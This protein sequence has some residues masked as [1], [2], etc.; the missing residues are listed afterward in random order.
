[1]RIIYNLQGLELIT[2]KQILG[3]SCLKVFDE[4]SNA[5]EWIA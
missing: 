2:E 3:G 4:Y 5:H 1:M